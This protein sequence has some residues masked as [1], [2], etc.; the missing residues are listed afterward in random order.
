MKC[1]PIKRSGR[2]VEAARRVIEI[3]EVLEAMRQILEGKIYIS[4]TMNEK[5]LNKLTA[6]G[7]ILNQ[8]PLEILS[9]REIEVFELLGQGL[10]TSQ[11]AEKLHLG[12]KTIET[13]RNQIK[14]KLNLENSAK[15][16]RYAVQ[17]ATQERLN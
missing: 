14:D 12:I 2:S 13:Y 15:L 10:K 7:P 17:W 9:D 16:V 6:S 1:K 3:D 8:S 4:P 11:I 5:F